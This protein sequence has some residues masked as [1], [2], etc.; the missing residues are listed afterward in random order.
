MFDKQPTLSLLKIRESIKLSTPVANVIFVWPNPD[1]LILLDLF[2][3]LQTSEPSVCGLIGCL[4][5]EKF[6]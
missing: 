2:I 1:R 3:H 6:S 5:S 4:K